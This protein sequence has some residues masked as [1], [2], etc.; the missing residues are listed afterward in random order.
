MLGLILFTACALGKGGGEG[1]AVGG[2]LYFDHSLWSKWD[3]FQGIIHDPTLLR[4]R[5]HINILSFSNGKTPYTFW[6]TK[7][8]ATVEIVVC[9]IFELLQLFQSKFMF[10]LSMPLHIHLKILNKCR[11]FGEIHRYWWNTYNVL[12]N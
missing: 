10:I 9:T 1:C 8:Q 11:E 12:F 5:S 6:S 2:N 4:K 7:S 3:P